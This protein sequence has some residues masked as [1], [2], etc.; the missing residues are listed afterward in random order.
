MTLVELAADETLVGIL[1]QV[2][3]AGSASGDS[4]IG[5]ILL[6][7]PAGLRLSAIELR[8]VRREAAGRELR[9]ALLTSDPALR[10][11][12]SQEG[13]STFRSRNWAERAPWRRIRSDR[14]MPPPSHG[15]SDV[16]PP[17]GP[18]VKVSRSAASFQPMSFLRSYARRASPWWG[19]LGL[20]LTLLVL[21]A[22]LY[23]A[24]VAVLPSAHVTVAPAAE[25]IDVTV[26]LLAMQD[27]QVDP[28][29]GIVPARALSVQVSGEARAPTTG[30]RQEPN[31]KSRGS[32]LIVNRTSAPVLVPARTV[33]STATGNNVRFLT[34]AEAPLVANG[35][36]TVPIE[37]ELP[38]P[39]GNARAGTI[40]R[41]EGPLALSLLATNDAPTGGGNT[42]QV[43]VVTEEDKVRLQ[44]TLFEDLKT[45][46][47]EQLNQRLEAGSF[48]PAES[49]SYLVLSPTFTPFVGE[50][51]PDLFLSMS[52]QAVGLVVDSQAGQKVALARLESAMPPGTRLISDTIRYIPGSVV[53]RDPQTISFSITAEGT[54]LRNI[55]S[56]A[57]RSAITRLD[58]EEA[59]QLLMTRFSLSESPTIE[60]GPP[61]P[62]FDPP[63]RLPALPWRIRVTV[64]WDAAAAL[65]MHRGQ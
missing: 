54:L 61:W 51:S 52:V 48:I 7:V 42:A 18:P 31:A 11:A 3:A 24:F 13:I 17:F 15:E 6:V 36:A 29:T 19:T 56:G 16:A 5:R 59:R 58:P 47:F 20:L 25:P 49:V 2:R 45:Q 40:T 63:A 1:A 4:E 27:A 35:R 14:R 62:F 43:G 28:E 64:D 34:T 65:A 38:G 8:L 57:V 41:V 12:A 21:G 23:F 22:A 55:D 44:A 46:A 50:V 53:M 39:S 30:R 37:A 32:V 9:L 33:V 26:S 60:L 10:R